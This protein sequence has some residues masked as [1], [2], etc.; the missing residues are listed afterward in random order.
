MWVLVIV[1]VILWHVIKTIYLVFSPF[2]VESDKEIFC[3]V[4][5]VNFR[6]PL[7]VGAWLSEGTTMW[8]EGWNFKYPSP[9][10]QGV[11]GDWVQSPMDNDL[12][13]RV[14]VMKPAQKPKKN[15]IQRA[16]GLV[17]TWRWEENG[18]F[19]QGME[20]CFPS[21]IPC[22]VHPFHLA[23]PELY[24]LVTEVFLCVLWADWAN[25]QTQWGSPGNIQF[26]TG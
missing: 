14:Y 7:R 1:F 13:N 26:V 9:P 24:N 5:R 3:Y 19:K 6:K 2:S 21:H 25:C 18:E 12:I 15:G 20:T 16:F 23:V 8:L 17:N 10:Q 11:A 4:N 22:P